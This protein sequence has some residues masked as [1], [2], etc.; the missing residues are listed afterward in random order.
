MAPECKKFH[1]GEM[2]GGGGD[3]FGRAPAGGQSS[4]EDERT[5]NEQPPAIEKT[6]VQVQQGEKSKMVGIRIISIQ[7]KKRVAT[8]S[9]FA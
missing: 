7:E 3:H 5:G 6:S 4:N 1:R 2:E 9:E 8:G